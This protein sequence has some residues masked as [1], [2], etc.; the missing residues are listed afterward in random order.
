MTRK[1]TFCSKCKNV[2]PPYLKVCFMNHSSLCSIC[3]I[4]KK[5]PN[6]PL[7]ILTKKIKRLELII[8]HKRNEYL[9]KAR[10]R[11]NKNYYA[12]VRPKKQAKK[13]KRKPKKCI[14]CGGI[15]TNRSKS[16]CSHKCYFKHRYK[17]KFQDKCKCGRIKKIDSNLC[18]FC[19]KTTRDAKTG[20]FI[21]IPS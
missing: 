13:K 17:I 16:F 14:I 3:Y 15:I 21:K 19:S 10:I 5:N 11:Q 2:I 20:K 9:R 12:K 18:K 6:I 4:K 1:K 7:A 8:E